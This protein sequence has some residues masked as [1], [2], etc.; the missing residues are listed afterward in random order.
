MYIGLT[1]SLAVFVHMVV[2]ARVLVCVHVGVYVHPYTYIY[3]H[4]YIY[5]YQ[6][7]AMCITKAAS[8]MSELLN[9]ET[10]RLYLRLLDMV[11]WMHCS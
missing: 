2:F 6:R 11:Q 9:S 8:T 7:A 10:L 4:I 5:I 3:L 1:Y